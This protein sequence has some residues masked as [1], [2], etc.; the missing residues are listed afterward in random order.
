MHVNSNDDDVIGIFLFPR[1][2][3]NNL[4]ENRENRSFIQISGFAKSLHL[5]FWQENCGK[6]GKKSLCV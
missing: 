1:R 5:A 6:T 4:K 3:L 2:S